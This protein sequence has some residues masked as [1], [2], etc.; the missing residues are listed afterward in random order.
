MLG[1]SKAML[2]VVFGGPRDVLD[3][4]RLMLVVSK[5]MLDIRRICPTKLCAPSPH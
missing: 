5:A 2:N 1:G 4:P 3:G